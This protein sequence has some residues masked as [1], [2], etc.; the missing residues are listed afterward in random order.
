MD[1]DRFEIYK[2]PGITSSMVDEYIF[3][4]GY[5]LEFLFCFFIEDEFGGRQLDGVKKVGKRRRNFYWVYFKF[6]RRKVVHLKMLK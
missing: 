4:V 1:E 5:I 3:E 2:R 6:K